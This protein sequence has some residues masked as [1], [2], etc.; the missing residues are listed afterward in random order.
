LNPDA[1]GFS[2]LLL[3]VEATTLGTFGLFA[4]MT[5]DVGHTPA[6]Q[7]R[8]GARVDVFVPTY[9]EDI[10]IL[11]ATLVG[12][13]A[14]SYPHITYVLDDGRRPQ[15]AELAARL[16]CLYLTRPDNAHA[17]AGNLNAALAR[18]DGEFIVV[19]DA[20]TVPQPDFLD[21]TLGYFVDERVALV[22]LPQ[23]FYNRDSV[24]HVTSQDPTNLWNE[25][26]LFYR[27]IQPGKNRWGAAFWCGS[28]SVL[29][30]AA[31]LAVGGVAT[32]SITEDLETSLRLHAS[33]WKTV[34]SSQP[35][36]YGIAAQTLHAFSVQRLR[37]AQGTMQ[38]L[39]SRE[40]PL[41]L[42]GLTFPQRLCHLAS[43]ATYL[44]SYTKLTYLLAAPVTL[45]TGIIPLRVDAGEFLVHWLPY[46][47][48]GTL[49][50]VALGRGSFRLLATERYNM[51]KMF[52]FIRA[53]TI[54]I[55]PRTLG[56]RVTP[57]R[58]GTSPY[59]LD[60]QELRPHFVLLAAIAAS[61]VIGVANLTCAL[62]T[63]YTDPVIAAVAIGW[64]TFSGVLLA[65]TVSQVMRR[66]HSREEYRF[67]A[68]LPA[69]IDQPNGPWI[70][71]VTEDLSMRGCSVLLD[72]SSATG[73][74][75]TL[76]MELPDG[77][78]EVDVEIVHRTLLADGR[79]RLGARFRGLRAME[80]ERLVEFLFVTVAPLQGGGLM[81]P[82][83]QPL[84]DHALA[85]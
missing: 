50:N 36:A 79:L 35:L 10:T 73:G 66:L 69:I 3:G 7:F 55:W 28:P 23:E 40:N 32:G 58:A 31:L 45:L 78:L 30:R 15:V 60:R 67:A 18:T 13:N 62:T 2:L 83:A 64:A 49:A 22:Q 59:L 65:A 34:Y 75:L 81:L 42:P 80:R 72:Q 29:R 39:R 37:W 25:Q 41:L 74:L 77:L 85:A 14:I 4:F 70:S 57:K 21:R 17:K 20:D 9:N 1:L 47:C 61:I 19:L 27:V 43:M 24:Q 5:W 46:F 82:Q 63:R 44:E 51:L 16:G 76:R 12:C 8:P 48:L 26:E 33:G 6:F 11:E 68:R 54:L 52:T 84:A 71:A 38:L 56:F 53:S